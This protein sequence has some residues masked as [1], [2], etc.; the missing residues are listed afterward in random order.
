M[1][2]GEVYKHLYSMMTKTA[3]EGAVASHRGRAKRRSNLEYVA[4]IRVPV[5]VLVG[6]ADAFIGESEMK[7]IA[8][9]IKD[10]KF[11]VIPQAGHMPN[12]EQPTIFNKA[13]LNFYEKL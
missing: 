4:E 7:E 9:R 12:M 10:S 1:N 6:D 13:I 5:L 8:T 3:A 11:V 2:D